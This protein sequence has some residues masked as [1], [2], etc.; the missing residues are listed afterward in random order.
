M[1][2]CVRLLTMFKLKKELVQS[3]HD[4]LGSK[5]TYTMYYVLIE[6]TGEIGRAHV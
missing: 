3:V 6:P 2:P 5:Y 4:I 1:T